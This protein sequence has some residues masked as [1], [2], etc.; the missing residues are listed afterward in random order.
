MPFKIKLRRTKRYN[1]LHKNCFVSKIRLLNSS[2]IE[3]TLSVESTGMECLVAVAQRAELS[4]THYFGLWFLS[5]SQQAR[6][7]ELEKPLKKQLDK[8]SVEPLLYFGVMFYVPSVSYLNQSVTRYQYYLQLKKDVFDG[9]L[10]G[11]VEQ[12]VRLA[13]LAVQVEFKSYSVFET[14]DF[15]RE[16]MLFPAGWTQDDALMQELFHKVA[17]EHKNVSR[18]IPEEAAVLYIQ[19]VE[20][21]EGYGQE[22]FHVKDSHSNDVSLCIFFM[23]I[24]VGDNQGKSTASYRWNDIGNITHNKSAIVLELN[25]KEEN[26]LFH[27]DDI[28]N[29]KYISRLFAARMKFYKENKICTEQP[30]TPPTV[31]RQPTW[32]R[33]SVSRQQATIL[34]PRQFQGNETF[35]SEDSIFHMSDDTFNFRSQNSLDRYM[36]LNLMNGTVP[37]GSVSSAHSMSSLNHSQNF[38]QA[39]PM[40]SNLSIT[41]NDIMRSD[42]IPKCR[43]SAIIV[44]SYR[45]TPDY[46][47]VMRQMKRNIHPPDSQSQSLRN[48]N[49]GNTHAYRHRENL[50]YSQPEIHD[51]PPYMASYGPQ[52]PFGNKP[53]NPPEQ[54]HVNQTASNPANVKSISHTVSTPELAN[55]PPQSLSTAHIFRNFLPRPPP[56]YPPPR[57]ASSTP[58]LASHRHKRVSA[59]SPDLVARKVQQSVKTFQEDSSPVVRQ[60]FQEVSETLKPQKHHPVINKRHSFEVMSHMVR[61]MEAMTLKS[62]NAPFP[63]RNT[64]R[65]QLYT[66]EEPE[67][68]SHEAPQMP[69]YHHKK[70]P[71]DATMLIHSSESEEEEDQHKPVPTTSYL[72]GILY[73]TQL[74]AALA[75]I[76]NKPPPEYPGPRKSVS[77]GALR[78]ESS[79]ISAAIARARAISSRPSQTLCMARNEP[80]PVAGSTLGP[81]LSEPDLSSVKERVKKEPV[82]ERPVSEMF[83]AEDAIIEREIMMRNLQKQEMAALENQKRPLMLAA[84]NGLA[85]SKIPLPGDRPDD[86]MFMAV[87]ERCNALRRKLEEGMVFTE[88][89][90]IPKRKADGVFATAV[91]P[92]NLERNRVREVLPYEENRVQLVPTKENHTGYINASHIK[93]VVG[94]KEWHYIATQGPLPHTF[95]DFWQ[96]VWEQG[97]NVIAMVMAEEEEG[98]AKSH[99]YWPKLGS[100]HNSATYG[101]FKVT[102]NFRTDSGY[103]ATTGLKIKHLLSGQERAVWHLQFTDWPEK[104]CPDEVQ[105]F[106]SYLEEIQSVRQY[107]NSTPDTSSRCNPPVLVHCS[108]GVGR[109]GVVILSELMMRCLENNDKVEIP[110]MLKYLREQRMFMIQTIAQYTFVYQVLI[111]FLESSRL[112]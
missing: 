39:S 66:T 37:N 57:P 81:S 17:L 52:S 65:E 64:L 89:E 47:T 100:R 1:V 84:L 5:K 11:T 87:D 27:T 12:Y 29:S 42:Y 50:V 54:I 23:G 41:G 107:A 19:E 51:R 63:R 94:D 108:A 25:R 26:V 77:N 8:F 2:E 38:I 3:C 15:L 70:T 112:I 67:Q 35:I 48:L 83:S 32:S 30:I 74:Q 78:P 14:H 73:S 7:V 10:R 9:R 68:K 33:S 43:H 28:E 95:H 86:A 97:V 96:M 75:R 61:G 18:F 82:K 99:R 76:P 53:I 56:P 45:Q 103:Y 60:S 71:S 31:R 44:P 55:M 104:G 98:R 79:C 62:L 22:C 21:M 109:T 20:R 101:K 93:V 111:H 90:Q 34:P 102:T 36:E 40:S 13:A 6:W 85:V 88:F 24:C 46:E 58:D 105:K 92:E 106:L 59:S 80:G 16:Y 110:M 4:E 72:P 49:I 91:L 69:V